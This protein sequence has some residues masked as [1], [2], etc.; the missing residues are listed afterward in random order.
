MI[1]G[2]FGYIHIYI[3]T[4]T[5]E[6]AN[7]MDPILPILS[8]LGDWAILLGYFWRSRCMYIGSERF[9]VLAVFE[10][11]LDAPARQSDGCFLCCDPGHQVLPRAKRPKVQRME[12]CS[13]DGCKY[14][15]RTCIGSTVMTSQPPPGPGNYTPATYTNP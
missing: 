4:W 11:Q 3:Y 9:I 1:L 10:V 15:Y 12:G 7:I 2:P 14:H 13:S 8:I 5:S 6:M